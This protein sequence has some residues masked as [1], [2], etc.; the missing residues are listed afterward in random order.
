MSIKD[1]SRTIQLTMIEDSECYF[2]ISYLT[3]TEDK[4]DIYT[5]MNIEQYQLWTDIKNLIKDKK[6]FN[7]SVK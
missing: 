4:E 5:P 1:I 2:T 6:E 7:I 3:F